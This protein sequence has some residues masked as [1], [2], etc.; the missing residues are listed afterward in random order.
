MFEANK[1]TTEDDLDQ[2]NENKQKEI[3]ILLKNSNK[4]REK[5]LK[6]I[7]NIN[8]VKKKKN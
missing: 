5:K 4:K 7:L 2:F 8:G 3:N 6:K 1:G